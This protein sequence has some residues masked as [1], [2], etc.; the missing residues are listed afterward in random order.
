MELK[1]AFL[2]CDGHGDCAVITFEEQGDPAC[3]VVDGGEYTASATALL[4][5]LVSQN[6]DSIDLMIGSHIDQ[7]HIN[8]LKIF[9]KKE[10]EKKESNDP[11]IRVKEY[12]GPLP[13][14]E[15]M[16]DIDPAI[17]LESF[18]SSEEMSWQHYVIKSVAQNDDLYEFLEEM[19][20]TIKH[21]AL[22]DLPTAPFADVKLEVLGPD[23]Q[24]PADQIIGTA[25][26]IVDGVPV[27]DV[28]TTLEDLEDAIAKDYEKMAIAAK[29]NANNQSIVFRLSLS[30][31]HADA[32]KWTF[33]FTGDAEEE[34]WEEMVS[35][36]DVVGKL[37][38]KVLKIPHHGSSLN[39]ITSTGADKVDADYSVNSVGQKHGLPDKKT[40]KLIQG[41]GSEILCPQR[42]QDDGHPSACHNVPTIECPAK[43]NPKD[44]VFTI[45]S[46]TG[47]CT[48]EPQN[49]EC[50]HNWQ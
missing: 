1:V 33:L 14:E 27:T 21:P 49:R 30:E 23:T 31:G 38:S 4:N 48:L 42:N 45:D 8:G 39:G 41:K 3:I 37:K 7:D 43:G 28:I 50:S 11:Y 36:N 25:L 34:A 46:A 26:G 16:P 10:L 32:L 44:V 19:G 40:M 24:I 29:R 15:L 20:T 22:D 13:T 9:V 18:N 35:N 17:D 6:V 47:D 5:Y 2:D 12:W